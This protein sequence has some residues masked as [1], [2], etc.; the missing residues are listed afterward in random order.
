[1]AFIITTTQTTIPSYTQPEQAKNRQ[2]QNTW[3][4]ECLTPL[5]VSFNQPTQQCLANK[6]NEN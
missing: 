2:Q 5:L 3:G 4:G 6:E 1:M